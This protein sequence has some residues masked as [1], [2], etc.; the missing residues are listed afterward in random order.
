MREMGEAAASWLVGRLGDMEQALAALVEVNSWTENVEGGRKVGALLREHFAMPGLVA[1]V[2]PSTRYADH[3]VFRSEGRAGLKPV[4]LVG[5][6]DTVFPPGKF[7]GYRKDGALRRGPGVLDMKG[8]L[9]TIA[10][11][12]KALAAS[13]GLEKLPPLRLV[14]VADEEVGSPEGAGVIQKAIAGAEAC[15]VFESG[16]ANDAI[17]TR[18]KG[19]GMA[20]A[21]A[22]GKAAHA[23]NNHQDGANALWALARFVDRVQQLTDYPKGVTV[24]VGK[25]TGGQG[26]NTVPDHATAEVDLRF[27]S[28]ADGE[29]LVRRFHHAA[30][31]ASASVPGTRIE[32]NGGVAREPLERTEASAALMAAYG[33]CAHASGLGHGEAALVGGGSD[34]STS[35]AMGIPS[36]DGLGPRGK[37]FHTVDEFIEVDTLIPKAQALARYLASRAG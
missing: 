25:V 10:W 15:L 27:C 4:A 37:G 5:H 23:G 1:E 17:I 31:E 13:G 30:Q 9:V 14:V 16:R 12:L 8:G 36:I 22:H 2:V 18:R 33:T 11:A 3:L 6:L 26:K 7:E 34:A 29:E 19:T 32:V 21:V 20:T 35:S 28:R 24:N